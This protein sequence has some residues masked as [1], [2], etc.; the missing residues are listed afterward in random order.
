M[1]KL[2]VQ[3]NNANV[4]KALRN[5]LAIGQIKGLIAS[6]GADNFSSAGSNRNLLDNPFFTVRQRGDGP[7]TGNVYGVDRWRGSNSRTTVTGASGYITL[8]TNSSG[9]GFLRQI[10]PQTYEGT[11]T[12]S[13]MLRGT[14]SGVI[15]FQDSGGTNIGTATSYSNVGANWTLISCTVTTSGT[16]IGG[17][18]VRVDTSTSVDILCAKMEKGG[19]STLANDVP[20]DYGTEL[21]KC[22]RYFMRLNYT[23]VAEPIGYGY[24]YAASQARILIPT[25]VPMRAAPTISATA[26]AN[27]RINSNGTYLTPSGFAVTGTAFPNGIAVHFGISGATSGALALL[28]SYDAM[29]IDFSA[30]L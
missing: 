20:P 7:F 15:A 11:F 6:D 13:V 17:V 2:N 5:A 24:A 10:L 23:G 1:P 8:S 16:P 19:V 25:P 22:M 14:G 9:N 18:V 29:Y 30:D 26:T 4:I 12:Y 27:L 3:Q 21:L 28:F